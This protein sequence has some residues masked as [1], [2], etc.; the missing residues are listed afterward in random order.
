MEGLP[1]FKSVA[2]S[3]AGLVLAGTMAATSP[4][5]AAGG[6]PIWGSVK[7]QPVYVPPP[8]PPVIWSGV[9]LGLHVG[10]GWGESDWRFRNDSYFNTAVGERF[11]NDPEGWLAGG[12]IGFNHQIG[13]FVWG[14]EGS[15][16][17]ADISESKRSPFFAGD[18]FKTD[19]D[20]LWTVT[21]RLGFD[22]GR[23]LTYVKGGYA[24]ANVEISA[25]DPI[26]PVVTARKDE[27]HHGW[28][29]GG[30]LEYLLSPNVIFGV[31]YNFINLGE[32]SHRTLA[33]DTS[34]F[35]VENDVTV[36]TVLARLSYKFDR[37]YWLLK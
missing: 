33:S 14:I 18:R 12:H 20:T 35:H 5:S 27:T 17:G 23:L 21:G 31:E 32:E 29:V 36:H 24:G 19:I 13:Q 37:N 11:R 2:L 9:Y 22:W 6:Y 8:P 26:P 10:Y 28:T 1:V 30:G 7:D 34:L 25:K 4:V 3:V 15:L 16:A